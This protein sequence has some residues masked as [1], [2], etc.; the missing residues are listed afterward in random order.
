MWARTDGPGLPNSPFW[1]YEA[2][3]GPWGPVAEVDG[4]LGFG[5]KWRGF[6]FGAGHTAANQ[7]CQ[8][9]AIPFLAAV[10]PLT[11]ISAFLL[12]FNPPVVKPTVAGEASNPDSPDNALATKQ[13]G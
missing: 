1:F 5:F 12:L 11:L 3:T 8:I 4:E 10:I 13:R 6:Q 2:E 7:P 9:W